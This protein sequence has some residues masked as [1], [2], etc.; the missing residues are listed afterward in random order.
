MSTQIRSLS[1]RRR[2]ARATIPYLY[3]DGTN[4]YVGCGSDASLDDLPD[5][6]DMTV[7]AWVRLDENT[8][9]M[10][11]A[12][13]SNHTAMGWWLISSGG[14]LTFRINLTTNHF[15]VSAPLPADGRWHFA[16]AYW[17]NTAH[18][19]RISLDGVWLDSD[20]G[21]GNYVSDAAISLLLGK[22][23]VG[24]YDFWKGGLGWIRISDTDRGGGATGTDFDPPPRATPPAIDA[25]TIEQ[26]NIDEG[27]GST[28]AAQVNSPAN[29]G[30]ISGATWMKG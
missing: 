2:I 16:R 9:S 17:D 10:V 5:G 6:H 22:R 19:G 7:E 25:N 13:K 3:F 1:H 11:V 21:V 30:T 8:G 20:A 24:W 29:D 27:A 18:N 14:N 12:S 4:D 23:G 15:L 26:W 28:A